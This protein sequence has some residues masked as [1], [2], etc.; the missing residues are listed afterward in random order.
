L[1]GGN[2]AEIIGAATLVPA[3]VPPG[4]LVGDKGYD[5]RARCV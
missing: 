5:A 1:T 2:V 3:F 4:Q